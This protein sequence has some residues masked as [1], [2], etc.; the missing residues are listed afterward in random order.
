MKRTKQE[1]IELISR[2]SNAF[3]PSGFED[4]VVAIAKEELKNGTE[5]KEDSL[6]NLYIHSKRNTGNKPK[7]WLDAHSDEVGFIIQAIKPNGTLLFL[8]LGGWD[9]N[10]IPASK[11]QI[12]NN[13]GNYISGIVA[14]KPVHFMNEQERGQVNDIS[15]MV[16][17]VG[18][19][20]K[21]DVINNYHI[22]IAN[23]IVPDVTCQYD[24]INQIFL[25]KAF[26]CRIGVASL[27]ET[28]NQINDLSLH[29]DVVGTISVQE[30]VGERGTQA[31]VQNIDA[32]IAII[33]EGCPADDTFQEEYLIQAG[34]KRG[35][36]LRYFDR[37][38]ITNPRFMKYALAIAEKYNIPT[39]VSV[40]SG[41]G[42]N[43]KYIHA[44]RYGVP[45]IVVG[46][47]VRYIHSHYG[48]VA[49]QDYIEAT[50]LVVE[51]LKD[52]N[53][54]VIKSF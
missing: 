37:S 42:T 18:A 20:S 53:E 31:A 28:F 21:D 38:M 41:G 8:P 36:N 9:P 49:Y 47:P 35:P 50:R 6:R 29:V 46:V 22:A 19:I 7:V 40:R 34:I 48:Y 44:S 5:R 43:A 24:Q 3:G 14:S 54:E 45:T 2:L 39:Q 26:D 12:K 17:D 52:I 32:D 13:H 15:S 27:I 4:E 33:F 51:I 1:N 10:N 11:L 16:I 30:E 23:P 25:G